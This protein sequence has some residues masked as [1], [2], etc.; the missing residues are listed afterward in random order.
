MKSLSHE[1]S[2]YKK[3]DEQDLSFFT[4]DWSIAN[5]A[6]SIVYELTLVDHPQI[7]R[8]YTVY[9]DVLEVPYFDLIGHE[10]TTL[11]F[12]LEEIAEGTPELV[13]YLGFLNVPVED[14]KVEILQNET[15]PFISI[16]EW[17]ENN[18]I[19]RV[20]MTE[21]LTSHLGSY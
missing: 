20:N 4:D 10:N 18:Y 15:A 2:L 8:F 7:L 16:E 9:V 5:T 14:Y 11:A 3:I 17:T 13:E 1:T 6:T 12:D 21:N 19:L